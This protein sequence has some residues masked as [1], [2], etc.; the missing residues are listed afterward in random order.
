MANGTASGFCP[1]VKQCLNKKQ[2]KELLETRPSFGYL[3]DLSG[4]A[5]KK[6][7]HTSGSEVGAA[8]ALRLQPW[9]VL[10]ELRARRCGILST[11]LRATLRRGS[12]GLP[13]MK[14]KIGVPCSAKSWC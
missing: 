8:A 4:L 7:H 10:P 11:L 1:H 9:P 3:A 2:L 13:E 12:M 6:A 5:S 14:P